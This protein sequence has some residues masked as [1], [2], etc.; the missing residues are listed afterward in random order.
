[1][2]NN[3][4]NIFTRT[5]FFV[6]LN[7]KMCV[8]VWGN[9]VGNQFSVYVCCRLLFSTQLRL[10]PKSL[11]VCF[12]HTLQQQQ[13]C[14]LYL[15]KSPK[16]FLPK[17]VMQWHDNVKKYPY[18]MYFCLLVNVWGWLSHFFHVYDCVHLEFYVSFVV[19]LKDYIIL[20]DWD[21]V[22]LLWQKRVDTFISNKKLQFHVVFGAI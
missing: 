21:V 2:E 1:M 4:W 22:M 10:L 9:V 5:I 15:I 3:D 14:V 18:F 13:W 16:Y 11:D 7:K 8:C 17:C 19:L 12:E 6:E 20:G